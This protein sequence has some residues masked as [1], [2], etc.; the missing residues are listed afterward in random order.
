MLKKSVKFVEVNMIVK[1]LSKTIDTHEILT[2]VSFKLNKGDKAGLIGIN[3]AGKTTLIK[4]LAGEIPATSGRVDTAEKIGYLKQEIPYEDYNLSILEFML[5]ETGLDKIEYR[6]HELEENLNETNMDEYDDLLN[7]FLTCDGYNFEENAKKTLN[8]LKLEKRI[9]QKI[10][11]LSGGEKNKVLLAALLLSENNILLLDEPTNNLDIDSVNFLEDCIIQSDKSFIIVSHDEYFLKETT[12]KTLELKNGRIF[13]YPYSYDVFLK[14]QDEL[15]KKQLEDYEN[16]IEKQKELQSRLQHKKIMASFASS[17][18]ASDNDKLGHNYAVA[19]G[20]NKSGAAI[21]R[22]TK[23]LEQTQVDPEFRVKEEYSFSIENIENSEPANIYIKDLVCGYED[24]KTPK[25]NL[26]LTLGDRLLVCGANGTGKSTLLKAI[27][28]NSTVLSGEI[29]MDSGVKFGYIEQN[30]INSD[31]NNLTLLEYLTEDLPEIDKP[32]IFRVLKNFQINYDDKDKIFADF[33]AG[34]RTKIN[35]AKLS[36]NQVNTL[37]LDE[38]TNHLDIEASNILYQALQDFNGTIIA[39]SHNK[40]MCDELNANL[41][42]D[43]KTGKV[44]G[45]SKQVSMIK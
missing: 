25:L 40:K 8:G 10:K 7:R 16:T 41:K 23:E 39:V 5:K 44:T 14:T 45:I 37:I 32:K 31:N 35:L 33:S 22:L 34:Q 28:N 9:D 42:L 24:F 4:I 3:G 21:K 17:S 15:Y 11:V 30:T 26:S 20:Q 18:S 13:E 43:I 36:L 19:R 27:L 29:I 6:M 2:D 38:P 1:S 12:T